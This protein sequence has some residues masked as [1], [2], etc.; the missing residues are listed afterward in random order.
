MLSDL[1][2]YLEVDRQK[3]QLVDDVLLPAYEEHIVFKSKRN[4][5]K[6]VELFDEVDF[7]ACEALPLTKYCPKCHREFPE[8]ANFCYKCSVKL[9]DID[10]I[11]DVRDIRSNPKFELPGKS[12][13]ESFEDIFSDVNF[14]KINDFE[15]KITDYKRIIRQIKTEAFKNYDSLVSSNELVQDW[16]SVP[17]QVLLFSKSF[18]DV[19]YKSYGQDLGSYG[20]NT[21]EIDDRQ[22]SSLQITTLIHELAHFILSEIL[23]RVL[24]RILDCSKNSYIEAL[25]TFILSYNPFTR[26]IDEYS[27]H[28]VEGRFTVY[29]YQD[30]SSFLQIEKSLDGEMPRDEIEITKS[31]GNTFAISIKDILESYID[32]D[33][34]EDIKKLF[35]SEN[36]D[37]PNY[38]MLKLENCEKLTDEGFLKAIWLILADGFEVAS[39]NVEKLEE[40]ENC[41]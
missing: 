3:R 18:A 35:L 26:L 39:L 17:D 20:F 11:I 19:V 6:S 36:F 9:K 16:L 28:T 12:T 31:I 24:C 29:G 10:D 8:D 23:T 25:I 13:F 27:A 5:L 37:S 22:R 1:S 21:I 38:E 4:V 40:Y 41:F 7:D 34:R 33:M 2:R 15:F 30:Y 14:K 32:R